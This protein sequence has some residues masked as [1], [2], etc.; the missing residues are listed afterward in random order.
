MGKSGRIMKRK[1]Y[2]AREHCHSRLRRTNGNGLHKGGLGERLRIFAR[3]I[4]FGIVQREKSES[5]S[6][7]GEFSRKRGRLQ[8]RWALDFLFRK[9]YILAKGLYRCAR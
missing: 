5:K 9:P 7:C 3:D 1:I 4:M 2:I 6:F 8:P